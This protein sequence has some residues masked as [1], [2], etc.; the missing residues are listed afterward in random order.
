MRDFRSYVLGSQPSN[1]LDAV[2]H[3]HK[4]ELVAS[5]IVNGV[6]I[7]R[8]RDNHVHAIRLDWKTPCV[9]KANISRGTSPFGLVPD[10]EWRVLRDLPYRI[11]EPIETA[12][13][14]SFVGFV[15]TAVRDIHRERSP[16]GLRD[17][18][19]RESAPQ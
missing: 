13:R 14:C 16:T 9:A 8:G 5:Q 1:I 15:W 19:A 17:D 3:P 11:Q 2:A 6:Q 4:R 18:E 12:N 7:G 10:L